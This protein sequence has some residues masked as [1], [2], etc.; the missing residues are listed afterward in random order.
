MFSGTWEERKI[1]PEP[2]A[3]LKGEPFVVLFNVSSDIFLLNKFC[4]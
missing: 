1:P 4:F 2:P 3:A